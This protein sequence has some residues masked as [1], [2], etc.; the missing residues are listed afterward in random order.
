MGFGLV[1]NNNM[2]LLSIQYRFLEKVREK[3]R[4]MYPQ[5]IINE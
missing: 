4:F 3:D 5:F 2:I 1:L